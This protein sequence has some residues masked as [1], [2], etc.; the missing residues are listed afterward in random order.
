M[1]QPASSKSIIVAGVT[2]PSIES[3]ARAH[4]LNSKKVAYRLS[5]GWSPEEACNLAPRPAHAG[6]TAGIPVTVQG[7]QFKTLKEAARHY[8]R[9]YTYA[10]GRLKEGHSIESVMGLVARTDTL[11]TE[12]PHVAHQW[13]PSKNEGLK[14][15]DLAPYSGRKVWWLCDRG[16][17]WPATISSQRLACA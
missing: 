12:Y 3:A 9:S 10:I 14:P 5:R 2:Y 11:E 17:E 15:G 7:R 4:S 16:H 8:R 13:H 1:T 6:R